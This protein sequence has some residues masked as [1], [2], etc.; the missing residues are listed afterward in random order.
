[1][2]TKRIFSAL[3]LLIFVCVMVGLVVDDAL[4]QRSGAS[5]G[6]TLERKGLSGL[7]QGKGGDDDRA[8][9]KF[10]KW[11]GLGSLVVA[12]LVIKYL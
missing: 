8:P 5:S 7:L 1:M 10:Q 6:D 3:M 4:A 2:N 9:T 11:L 12:V